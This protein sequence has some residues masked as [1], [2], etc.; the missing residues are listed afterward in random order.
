MSGTTPGLNRT[1]SVSTYSV[2]EYA[3]G[4]KKNKIM[5]K[6]ICHEIHCSND[7]N[8]ESDKDVDNNNHCV[9][10]ENCNDNNCKDNN[11]SNSNDNDNDNKDIIHDHIQLVWMDDVYESNIQ[12]K[13]DKKIKENSKNKENGKNKANGFCL[14]DGCG[15]IS[16]NLAVK[17]PYSVSRGNLIHRDQGQEKG[18]G[19]G[20]N[21][22]D[23]GPEIPDFES[24]IFMINENKNRNK[25]ENQDEKMMESE[26][27]NQNEKDDVEEMYRDIPSVF[28]IRIFS[29]FGIFK[30]NLIVNRN[31]PD[32]TILVRH[33]MH[34]VSTALKHVHSKDDQLNSDNNKN[35]NDN[36][37]NNDNNN[38]NNNNSD[39]DNNNNDD[40]NDNNNDNNDNNNIFFNDSN[41]EN[42][43]DLY[44]SNNATQRPHQN[45]LHKN[46]EYNKYSKYN[47]KD[48]NNYNNTNIHS[49]N[50][51]DST[52][53]FN[54]YNLSQFQ[55]PSPPSTDKTF[56]KTY[57]KTFSETF[58]N[59]FQNSI[60]V[61]IVNT[62]KPLKSLKFY[63]NKHLILLLHFRGVPFR[64]FRDL[65]R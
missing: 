18:R 12:K 45:S 13:N 6:I 46:I 19:L 55:F 49:G 16:Y 56:S 57:S 14:T 52:T 48:G 17:L 5:E 7:R 21:S 10:N 35:N 11:N 62:S 28:Q 26:N 27:K 38:N 54:S 33:S 51:K 40:N 15:F 1:C 29:P 53:N 32:N 60:S 44:N 39:D 65:L 2:N 34:K 61:E 4:F 20:V 37:N 64:Y 41:K 59:S 25:N 31:I 50:N 24:S 23:L 36:G 30:G 9:I 3:E 22:E 63:L 43:S 58:Q 42:I 8:N 47:K